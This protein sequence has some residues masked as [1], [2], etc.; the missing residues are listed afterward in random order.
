MHAHVAWHHY[1]ARGFGEALA[2][3]ERVVRME[4]GF[5]WGHFFAGWALERLGRGSEAVAALRKAVDCSSNSP[6][7]LAGLGHGL[8]VFGDRRDALRVVRD[9]QRIRGDKGLFAYELGVI[10]AAL[11]DEDQ[12]FQWLALAVRERSGWI[13]YLRVDPRLDKL[14][15]D[16]RF[17]EL[18]PTRDVGS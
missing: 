11:G 18:T 16:A 12:A 10:H 3:S 7:M 9:L 4:P 2:Q 13:A 5:H 14:H 1:M 17:T 15:T 8:A 6:V